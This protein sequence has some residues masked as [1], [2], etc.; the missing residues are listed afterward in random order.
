MPALVALAVAIFIRALRWRFLFAPE[1]RPSVRAVTAAL[2]LGYLFNNILP[3]RAGEV[4]RVVA[5]HQRARTSRAETT[6]TVVIERAFDVLSLFVLLLVALP[7][8]PPT[9]WFGAAAVLGAVLA[10]A[11]GAAILVLAVYGDRP[12]RRTL[13]PLGRFPFISDDRVE[14]AARNITQ[15]FASIRRFRLGMAAFLWT[16]LSWLVMAISFWFVM[17]GFHL[18]LSPV[19]GLLVVIAIGLAMILPSAPAAVG[20]FE[21]ATLV[22][23]TAYGVGHSSALSYALVLHALNFVPFV[24]VGLLVLALHANAVRGMPRRKPSPVIARHGRIDAS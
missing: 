24:A 13:R 22:A 8:L 1:T 12:I 17:L 23:L 2:L 16:T 9:S 5:L 11:L 4:A 21:A 20:V 19:A 18:D 10:V 3:A 6:A 15:G 14:R 7:W